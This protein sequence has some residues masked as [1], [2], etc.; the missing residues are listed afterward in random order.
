MQAS[1]DKSAL[2][3]G[4]WLMIPIVYLSLG[5]FLDAA[6]LQ[7]KW[8]RSRIVPLSRLSRV[9]WILFFGMFSIASFAK[10]LGYDV[11]RWTAVALPV[12]FSLFVLIIL[13]AFRD[14]R[15]F[16]RKHDQDT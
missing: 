11:N 10:A 8:G 14:G 6:W 5:L 1:I 9:P 7:P 4:I 15:H 2:L 3:T 12:F 16:R 13:S